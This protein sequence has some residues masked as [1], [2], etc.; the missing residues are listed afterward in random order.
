MERVLLTTAAGGLALYL[1]Y[2]LQEG[3]Q[4]KVVERVVSTVPAPV[5]DKKVE[6]K[7]SGSASSVVTAVANSGINPHLES[8]PA[9]LGG[10]SASTGADQAPATQSTLDKTPIE[11]TGFCENPAFISALHGLGP[12]YRLKTMDEPVQDAYSHWVQLGHL[13]EVAKALEEH[14]CAIDFDHVV[15]T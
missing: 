11:V 9:A 15:E 3:Q 13:P 6:P 7:M 14:N 5:I 10:D 8:R 1:F 12:R 2:L 4:P